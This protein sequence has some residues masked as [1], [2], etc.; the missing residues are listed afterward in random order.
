MAWPARL[1]SRGR[2]ITALALAL[3]LIG[4]L[5]VAV[6]RRDPGGASVRADGVATSTT[7]LRTTTTTALPTTT[8]PEATTVPP[9]TAA[10]VD[11]AATTPTTRRPTS[12]T[13]ATT[14]ATVAPATPVASSGPCNTSSAGVSGQLA[15]KF[16]AYRA[17]LGLPTMHRT[18]SMDAV[19]QEWANKLAADHDAQLSQFTLLHRGNM[20]AKV[21]GACSTC[22]GW[23]ENIGY[24]MAADGLWIGWLNSPPHRENIENGRAGEFGF[25]AAQ[26]SD[27]Y[28]WGVENFGRYRS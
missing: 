21:L 27:G 3:L 18:A 5:A 19:A 10:P 24:A 22:T 4:A 12:T 2:S 6:Q 8:V 9:T 20:Q 28:W 14:P 16:C 15:A 25:G 7:A 13:R 26:S 1:P 23:A 17:G 11:T